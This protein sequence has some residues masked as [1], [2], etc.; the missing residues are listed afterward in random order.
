MPRSS[1]IRR[2]FAP[3]LG[4]ALVTGC[5]DPDPVPTDTD[6]ET[7]TGTGPV[8]LTGDESPNTTE[9][10]S[11][12]TGVD[13]TATTT[14]GDTDTDTDTDTGGL[15]GETIECD[16]VIAPAPAG[17]VCDV[18]P[19][20]GNLLLQGTV[21]AGFDTYLNGEVLVEGD[22]PN[23]RILCVG[24]DCGATAEGM[25]ATVVACEQ[26][27]I[28]PG[29]I[30][31]HDHITFTL[32]QPQGHGTERYDH[33]HEWRLGLDG[34]TELNT[35]PG[36]NSSR[37]GVLY[38]EVRMLLGG[39]TSISGSVGGANASGLL[40]NL[41]RADVTE[42]LTGV[43]V[44]Y[45]TFPLGDSNGTLLDMGCEY[46]FIDGS[47]NL[48]DDIYMPHI[49]EGINA[50]AN[51]EFAC[52]SGAPGGEDLI[53]GNTSVIHGIGMRPLDIDIMGQEGA[54]LVWSPRSNVDL[55]GITAD[56]TTYRNLGVRIA[57]G[58]D[59]TASGSMNVLR[60]LACADE[61]NRN[62]LDGAFSDLELWLMS[63]YWAAASQGAD[64]Q[65]GLIREGHI[66]DLAIFDG[67]MATGHR[68]V[69]EGQPEGV[70]L[71]LRGGQPLH[72]DAAVI[73]GLVDAAEVDGCETIDVCGVGKRLCAQR[74]A[75]LT[76]DQITAA[77]NA[78]SYP[79]YF[80]GDPDDE[81]SC[82]PARPDEFPDR[83][84]PDD[85]DGDGVADGSDN[86]PFVFNPVRP[87]DS[88]MQADS[89]ADG[90][91][92][93]CD[94]C[95]L[96][97]GEGCAVPDV[98]DQDGDGVADLDDNCVQVDNADQADGDDDG[99]GDACDACPT[100]PNPGGGPCPTSIYDIKDGTV[101]PGELVLVQDVVV[102]A[103]DLTASGFFVQVHPDD[104]GFMGVEYSGMYVY[105]GGAGNPAIG[106]RVDVTGTVNDFFGQIQLDA[107]DQVPAA[108]LSSGNPLPAP[109]VVLP[110]D[111]VEGGPLQA[112]MEG[113]LSVVIGVTVTN[114]NPAPGPGDDA[115]NEFE[116]T[117]GLRV[118]DLFYAANP[119]PM[120]GQ[121]YSQ[122]IGVLRW[123]NQYTKLEPRFLA[124]YPATLIGFGEAQSFLLEG[125]MA[126][127]I[128][129]LQVELSA[130][131]GGDTPVDLIYADP[132]I[133]TGPAQVIVPDGL[134]T[135][136]V[137]LTGVAIGTADVT[138]DLDGVQLVTSVR[139]YNDA[140]PR[141]PTLSP[142][143]TSM[144]LMDMT[145]LTVT[146]DIPAP[147]GD[148]LV[149]LGVAPGTCLTAPPD[150]TVLAGTLS[151]DF[152]VT[153]GAC[154]GDEVVTASIGPAMSMA[155]VSVVDAP[156]FPDIVIAEVYYDHPAGDDTFEWVKLYNGTGGPVDLSNY[157]L[158]WGGND[159]T[160]GNQDLVG[161]VPAGA[162]FVVGGPGSD[163]DNG[164]PVYDQ[165]V[166][167]EQ[168]MQ[169]SGAAADAVGLFD[170]PA[171]MI[172][173][174]SVPIDAVI[175]GP[176]NSN[177]LLDETGAP[178]MPDVGDAPSSDSIRLQS[179]F[180]WAIEVNP[181]PN[182][183][184]P[185]PGP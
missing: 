163:A 159:Y 95:P 84:G 83:G 182:D 39:A 41:D 89:D 160:W 176:V 63:T 91:G 104:A 42:G 58:T 146:L 11:T 88:G 3:L 101:V 47:F 152:T 111:V 166:N 73:E 121:T 44:N 60:E 25:T 106:D 67:S 68:A 13:T 80:C 174:G 98:F 129:G 139:V 179:D 132:G 183:C 49:A 29:L 136:P 61:F 175:Y 9:V 112:Q 150:V 178:G 56:I 170:I 28:T 184:L 100:V 27:V 177:G 155:T 90:L 156:A 40:R 130:P 108:V 38:G 122:I 71:V 161:I 87:L 15:P 141:V 120:A 116:V 16:N 181:A 20:D 115:T 97:P 6:T 14:V 31:P 33:R 99:T 30:N 123:A 125:A 10:D 8:T 66:A 2:A 117:G 143:M 158:G 53:E 145:D 118:N 137:V 148:Q 32:S 144:Q 76:T 62:H 55:Y 85:A 12:A 93:V 109:E 157:S 70:A 64:D 43:D 131:A 134:T 127:P 45:R 23:G 50:E 114:I 119:P 72:G 107:S 165:A 128:P 7:G 96:S 92:D 51:N 81:P 110:A 19:G 52:L 26:G 22:D 36:S 21:L 46:P 18:T 4:V 126:E 149:T 79:F 169:N 171:A 48:G 74:D 172:G 142:A 24:C 135:A 102:T 103:S 151:A 164:M 153:S 5:P 133:V 167:L 35:F 54:M 17:Q 138:A 1:F 168:D 162:C 82:D 140:E 57:L 124:D 173:A 65:I 180:S 185:F 34:A 69:I 94:L 77:V 59:W 105:T 86:C 37:E 78:A 113:V 75:G 147:A 154:T